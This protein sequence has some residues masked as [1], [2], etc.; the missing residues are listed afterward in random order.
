[1]TQSFDIAVIGSGPGGYR[2]AVLGALRERRVVVVEKQDWGGC[3]L[4]R[5]CVP[6]KDWY[7]SARLVAA[8]REFPGRGISGGLAVDLGRAWEHQEAVVRR[9]QDSYLDYMKR[10][11]ISMLSGT[12]SFASAHEL[13]IQSGTARNRIQAANVII[14]TGSQP[15]PTPGLAPQPKRILTTDMLFDE[16][17]PPGRRVAVIGGGLIGAEFAFILSMLG[18]EV[19]WVTRRSPLARTRFSPQALT[20]LKDA[21][22]AYGIEPLEGVSVTGSSLRNDELVLALTEGHELAV[23][24]AL[25]G[26]GRIPFTDGLALDAVGIAL[27][28]RGYVRVN[29]RLQTNLPHVY[30]VGDCVSEH[31]TANQAIADAAVAVQNIIAGDSPPVQCRRDVEW[32]PE[33]IYSAVELARLGLNEDLAEDAGLEPAVGFAAFENSPCALGQD[34]ARGFVRLIADLDSGALLGAEVAGAQAG[35]LIHL[36]E[37]VPDHA[38]ALAHLAH[39]SVNHPSRAEEFVNAAETLASKWGLGSRIFSTPD[40]GQ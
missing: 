35:E 39:M 18:L 19:R 5:G 21:L 23:D 31:M 25:L 9:V 13:D 28:E 12:A 10:L 36:L 30:A 14:A 11:G 37:L 2:A 29:E 17:P 15:A 6:K 16:P 7:H 27:D 24:W 20:L 1:M 38:S 8:S 22:R 33:V 3:C 26:T 40:R 4:N 32:V 34:D